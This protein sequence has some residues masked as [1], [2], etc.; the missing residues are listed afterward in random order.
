[1]LRAQRKQKYRIEV[2]N[3]NNN[4]RASTYHQRYTPYHMCPYTPVTEHLIYLLYN[5]I[6]M[7]THTLC[8]LLRM[9]SVISDCE[10]NRNGGPT[11]P[12]I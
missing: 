9:I 1:M 2:H 4:K 11:N 7:Y 3:D 8:G 5:T 6:A 12:I 10:N